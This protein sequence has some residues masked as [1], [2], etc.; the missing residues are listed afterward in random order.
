MKYQNIQS[1]H[2]MKL[3]I[4]DACILIDLCELQ[5]VEKFFSLPALFYTPSLVWNEL[6]KDYHI[7]LSVFKE[8]NVLIL[9]DSKKPSYLLPNSQCISICDKTGII[10]AKEIGALAISAGKVSRNISGIPI[11]YHGVIWII[12]QLV[13][14]NTISKNEAC[15]KL[16]ELRKNNQIINKSLCKDVDSRLNLWNT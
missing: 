12:E 14:Q 13:K 3:V 9:H 4:T 1:T 11:P 10:L 6:S 2:Q 8:D 15:V 5:L 7:L 16:V